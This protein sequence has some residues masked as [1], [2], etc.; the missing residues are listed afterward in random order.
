M[1]CDWDPLGNAWMPPGGRRHLLEWAVGL[2]VVGLV[3]MVA[4]VVFMLRVDANHPINSWSWLLMFGLF[5]LIN[6]C[7]LVWRFRQ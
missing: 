7:V 1:D 3:A 4:G 2:I 5:Q 6:G